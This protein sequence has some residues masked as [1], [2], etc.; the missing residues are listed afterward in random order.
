GPTVPTA[1]AP[2]LRRRR[3]ALMLSLGLGVALIAAACV[4]MVGASASRKERAP[5]VTRLVIEPPTGTQIVGGHREIAVSADGRQVAFI[6]QG[7]AD[8]HIYVRRLDELESHEVADTEGAR[9]LAFS[10]DGRWL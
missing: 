1:T 6:A 3:T 5:A 9:D 10:P 7:T 4:Y 8:Q 2:P